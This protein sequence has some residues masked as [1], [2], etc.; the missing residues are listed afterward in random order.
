MAY[1]IRDLLG[2]FV[3]L[4][5]SRNEEGMCPHPCCKGRRPHPDRFPLM[6]PSGVLRSASDEDLVR[7]F[8]KESVG[9]SGKAVAQ[10]VRELER[11]E[12]A[13]S[14]KEARASARAGRADEYRSWLENEWVQAEEATRGNLVNKRG[15]A[16]DI[17]PRAFWTSARLR[18]RYASDEARAYF[19]RHPPLSK[20]E[21][22][23]S[24]SAQQ[25]GAR[26]R[27]QTRLYGVY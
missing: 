11:R 6:L 17:D 23:D 10:V 1:N 14:E 18:D 25:R 7:H 24:H 2:H 21:F 3:K 16:R 13:R 8:Q 4:P 19:D 9:R 22:A 5:P 26:R 12:R 20:R 27:R 15:R